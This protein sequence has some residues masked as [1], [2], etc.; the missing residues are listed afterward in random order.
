[1]PRQVAKGHLTDWM[2]QARE[3]KIKSLEKFM[4]DKTAN[5]K[6]IVDCGLPTFDAL[7]DIPYSKFNRD[8]L[9]LNEFLKKYS[10][11]FVR[12]KPD[13]EHFDLV[14]R[15]LV[16]VKDFQD[17]KNFLKE[18][19][20]KN[21]EYYLIDILEHY[22]TNRSAVVI[23]N[24]AK[25]VVEMLNGNLDELCYGATPDSSCL[26]YL[27]NYG[28]L[29]ERTTWRLS[30]PENKDF[31][32]GILEVL[33]LGGNRFH[34]VYR[35]GYFEFVGKQGIN[36]RDAIVCFDWVQEKSYLGESEDDL[37]RIYRGD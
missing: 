4:T 34:P 7:M 16:G 30:K 28:Q 17:M 9:I 11:F 5:Q 20:Q 29:E 37:K 2:N 32:E 12:A 1:M 27:T 21:G 19:V 25:I 33:R 23:S 14:K 31:M 10:Q 3:K 8:N 36:T 24:R 18:V 22:P 6:K 13:S 26:I 35:K 15:P